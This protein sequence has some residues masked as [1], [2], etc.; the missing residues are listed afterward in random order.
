MSALLQA[1]IERGNQNLG[2][3]SKVGPLEKILQAQR[4]AWAKTVRWG[5]LQGAMLQKGQ[6]GHFC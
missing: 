3:L 1:S 6:H 5:H 4:T 2:P